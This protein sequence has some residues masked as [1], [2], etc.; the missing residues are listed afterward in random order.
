MNN[1]MPANQIKEVGIFLK[2]YKLP[3]LIQEELKNL[4]RPLI[5]KGVKSLIKRLPA[6]KISGPDDFTDEF[7]QTF[8]EELTPVLLKFF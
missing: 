5:K 4:N 6:K 1:F 8:K 3:K 2:T 7:Y